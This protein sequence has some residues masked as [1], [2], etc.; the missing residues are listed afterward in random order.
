MD[1]VILSSRDEA[2]RREREVVA[3]EVR[4]L[5]EASGLRRREFA[6]RIGT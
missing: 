4:Q 1:A 3:A 6:A 5:R 2:V